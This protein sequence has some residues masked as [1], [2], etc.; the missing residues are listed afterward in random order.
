MRAP[1]RFR[2]IPGKRRD[3]GRGQHPLRRTDFPYTATPMQYDYF[4]YDSGGSGL[5]VDNMEQ[6]QDSLPRGLAPPAPG[7]SST[8]TPCRSTASLNVGRP[9]H[10]FCTAL[11]LGASCAFAAQPR[12]ALAERGETLV[13]LWPLPSTMTVGNFQVTVLPPSDPEL[14]SLGGSGGPILELQVSKPGRP[15]FSPT[16]IQALWLFVRP[17]RNQSPEFSVWSKTGISSY[18]KCRLA[19]KGTRYC[20]V[21]CQDY[22]VDD[23]T[24]RPTGN[25]RHEATCN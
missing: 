5:Q 18:V 10:W 25:L 7:V 17:K 14:T 19:P 1:R 13:P 6:I 8:R 20:M 11:L 9:I 4:R 2:S 23:S 15:T 16:T 3:L 12:Q 24:V 22:D 21:W